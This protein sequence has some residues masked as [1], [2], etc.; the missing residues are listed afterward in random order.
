MFVD[1]VDVLVA[2]GKGGRGS[3]SFRREKFIPRGGPDG[4]DGGPGGSVYLVASPHHNTLVNF[5][6]HPEFSA[7]P[8]GNGAGS[9]RTGKTGKDL[10]LNVPVGT[11]AYA[12]RGGGQPTLEDGDD[13]GDGES[14]DYDDVKA[15]GR[16]SDDDARREMDQV[17]DLTEVGQTAL[18]AQGGRGGRG[19]ARFVSSTNRA[20]RRADPGDEGQI[21]KLHLR[22]KLL[23]DVGLIGF[24]NAGKSTLI[25]R[26]SAAKPKIADYP[27][28][29]LTPNLGVVSLDDDRSFVVADVP[30]L[31]EGAHEGHGLGHRFLGHV[32]RTKVLLHLVDVSSGSGR[33]PVDDFEII[34]RELAL[35]TPPNETHADRVSL[36]DRPQI[37]VAN[38][39]DALDDP[40]RLTRLKARA[41]ELGLAFHAISGATGVGIDELLEATW[42]YVAAGRALAHAPKIADE[43]ADTGVEVAS[44]DEAGAE[45]DGS[46]T[47]DATDASDTADARKARKEGR[48]EAA[49]AH[50]SHGKTAEREPRPGPKARRV[51]PE[52]TE[53]TGAGHGQM[54]LTQRLV[55]PR[56]RKPRD[57]NE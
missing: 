46:A 43:A 29:T 12:I 7:E 5:R 9:N 18:V 3:I 22:L 36:A 54:S 39:I 16:E 25:A 2:A 8:G 23:A 45:D 19:N 6:F 33:D 27:F 49:P 44:I 14:D 52:E 26:I 40:D 55:A 48:D 38:K 50:V 37:V 41:A 31:I 51:M 21:V 1:E 10:Y 4:G 34:R 32:E 53:V 42:Q 17:A 30:G 35:Y 28:T 11:T 24:P 56:P 13:E 57:S 20:P 47:G 15:G